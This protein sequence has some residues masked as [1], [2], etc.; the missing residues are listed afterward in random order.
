MILVALLAAA[1]IAYAC[2][3]CIEDKV[4]AVYDHVA[5]TRALEAKSTIVFFAIDGAIPPG[6]AALRKIAALAA[7]APGVDRDSVRISREAASLAVAF[8]PRR[9]NLATVLEVLDQRLA[10]MR[11]SLLAMR[12]MD[13][14]GDLAAVRR[15]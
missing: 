15:P 1:P 10:P 11:L 13:S 7:S 12:V 9:G 2:G 4:A 6:A 8:D 5:V 14:P 3:V